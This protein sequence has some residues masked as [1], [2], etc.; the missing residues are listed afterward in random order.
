MPRFQLLTDGQWE[1]VAD[2]IPRRTGRRGPLC[3]ALSALWGLRPSLTIWNSLPPTALKVQASQLTA[4][5]LGSEPT[6]V[7]APSSGD[8]ATTPES[9]ISTGV[10]LSKASDSELSAFFLRLSSLRF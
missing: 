3:A 10:R 5:S 7:R 1:M 9:S 2:P 4:H 6:S 8:S